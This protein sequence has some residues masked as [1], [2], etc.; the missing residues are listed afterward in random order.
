MRRLTKKGFTLAELLIVV[1]IIAVLVA[2]AIP[3][4]TTQLEKAR[5]A[6]DLANIRS[7]YAE[8][9]VD[10]ITDE[11]TQHQR[12]VQLKQK[13][14]GWKTQS[15]ESTLLSLGD[16]HDEPKAGG[17]CKVIW[18]TDSKKVLFEFGD[19]SGGDTPGGGE[20]PGSYD[21]IKQTQNIEWGQGTVLR[22]NSGMCVLRLDGT[23]NCKPAY[24][25]GKTV[26]EIC[27]LYPGTAFYIAESNIK[28]SSSA[29]TIKTGDVYYDSGSDTYYLVPWEGSSGELPASGWIK[30]LK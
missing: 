7:A 3:I 24:E 11:A 4:F 6:T 5:E 18:Q 25:N 28:D 30:L 19:G 2:I 12:T 10:A 20:T 29:N 8:V 16:V 27:D 17:T 21:Y 22:D 14:D 13:V 23:T 9:M 15:A 26:R 1:A